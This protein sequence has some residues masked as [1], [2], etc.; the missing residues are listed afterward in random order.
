MLRAELTIEIARSAA[1]VF[2]HL[3]DVEK[4]S[5]WQSSLVLARTEGAP[6]VGMHIVERRTLL[7]REAETELEV[8]A[9][10]PARRFSLRS[11]RGPVELEIDHALEEHDGCTTL[12]VDAQARAGGLLRLAG[13]AVEGRARHELERDF[14]RLKEIL[15][16]T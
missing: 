11:V 4:L 16:S 2:D 10:E 5:E 15:E 6:G 7:G 12:S 1:E 9:F 3:T 8:T 14:G 13:R